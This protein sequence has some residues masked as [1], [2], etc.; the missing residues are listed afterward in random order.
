MQNETT[1]SGILGEW[2]RLLDALSANTTDLP[3]LEASRQMFVDHLNQTQALLRL[4]AA[5]TAE[6]QQSSQDLR[7][8]ISDGQRMATMLRQGIKQ[9]FGIRSEKI[10]EFGLAPYRGKA[11]RKK[12]EGPPPP[13]PTETAAPTE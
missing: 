5:Q 12:P 6:K 7:M 11:G 2:Q 1:Y 4:Q 10:A 13:P 8:L 9:H 3:H